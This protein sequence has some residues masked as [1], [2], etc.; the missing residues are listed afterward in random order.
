MYRIGFK[1]LFGDRLKY[2]GLVMS[3][4]FATLLI[5]QQTAIF[6]GV[7]ERTVDIIDDAREVG[8]WSGEVRY[9]LTL[10]LDSGAVLKVVNKYNYGVPGEGDVQLAQTELSGTRNELVLAIE[11]KLI[12][13]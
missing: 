3:V 13:R 2:Y 10:R 5:T 4:A 7:M 6:V 8:M 1:M 9:L 12:W 11:L